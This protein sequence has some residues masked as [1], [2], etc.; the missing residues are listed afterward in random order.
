MLGAII[1][2]IVGS[3]FEFNNHRSK[4]FELFADRCFA[5]DDSIMTLAIAKAIMEAD[6]IASRDNP[7]YCDNLRELAVKYMREIGRNYPNCG[8]GGMFYKWIFSDTMGAYNSFGNGAAMRVSPCGFA[9]RTEAE[10]LLLA[11]TVTEVT[12]NHPEGIKGAEATALAIFLARNGKSKDEIKARIEADNYKLNFTID[13]IRPTYKFNETCQETVPQAIECFLEATDF[14]D[15][16]RTAISLGGDSDT[17]GAITG[18]ITEAFYSV[19]QEIGETALKYLDKE[20]LAVYNE[21]CVY[22]PKIHTSIVI[23]LPKKDELTREIEK[24]RT[25]LSMLV[26]ER[27]DLILQECKTIEMDYMLT[28]GGVEYKA[29]ELHCEVLRL[30]RKLELIQAARNR[31]EIPNP[32]I[33]EAILEREFAEYKAKLD[34]EIGKMNNALKRRHNKTLTDDEVVE[35]KKM[36]RVIVKALHPDLHPDISDEKIDFLKTAITAYEN[37][38]LV[39]LRVIYDMVGGS[40]VNELPDIGAELLKEKSRLEKSLKAVREQITEIKNSYPYNLKKILT[41]PAKITEIKAA[42][43]K[44][45]SELTEQFEYYKTKLAETVV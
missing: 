1:G 28:L 20:P 16:I 9:A 36:Y 17:I 42:A 31:Q 41:D 32:L 29:Y 2:D 26:L 27:D 24:L 10:A 34:E 4:D 44:Q 21:W 43:E 3:R 13:E 30:K 33:I 7:K 5:T 6:K 14:E 11:K 37:G 35:F 39:E 22:L 38:N 40:P 19:P 15:A 25:E 8:F 23:D 12:H 18:A 45:I